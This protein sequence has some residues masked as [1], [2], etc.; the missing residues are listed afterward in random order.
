MRYKILVILLLITGGVL[1]QD[2]PSDD[3]GPKNMDA[4]RIWKLT[5]ALELTEEQTVT[6]L[7]L[8]QIHERE[9]RE[10]LVE[11]KALTRESRKALKDGDVTQKDVDKMIQAYS[12][13]QDEIYKIKDD[14]IKSL[15][16]HLTPEQQLLY[17]GFEARFRS[18]LREYMKHDRKSKRDKYGKE[19]RQ[20]NP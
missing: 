8:V 5:E 3:Y 2:S 10:K 6:F 15:S 11:L 17:V 16:K 4:I 20:R 1:A 13:K 14:F 7:P 19:N 12:D 9:I 18:E